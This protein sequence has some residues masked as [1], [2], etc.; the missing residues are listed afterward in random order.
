MAGGYFTTQN[1]RIPGAYV[2][3]STDAQE[4]ITIGNRGIVTMPLSLNW[5]KVR[6]FVVIDNNTDFKAVLGYDILDPQ[7]LII[8]ETLKRAKSIL[9]YRI[10]TG[11]K[12]T[13]IDSSLTV[14][15]KYEGTRGNDITI[16]IVANPDVASSFIVT[17]Y[18][19]GEIVDEQLAS[20][21]GDL[22][23]ND[24]VVFSGTASTAL[25]ASAGIVLTGGTN[26]DATS[27]NYTTYFA[28]CE[29]QDFNVIALSTSDAT[30]KGAAAT[31]VKRMIETEG[32]K[33]Q[34]VMSSYSTAD[35]EGVISVENGVKLE[36]GT[37]IDI[38]TAVGWVAGA[39]A[40]AEINKDLTYEVYEGAVDVTERYTD[41]QIE[42]MLNAGKFFFVPKKLKNGVKKIVV[43]EDINTFVSFTKDKGKEFSINRSIR[44]MFDIGTTI[45]EFWE[46]TYI[47]KVDATD[48]GVNAF[49][50]DVINYF[51]NLQELGAIKNF[52]S[53]ED[54]K[55]TL[56]SDDSA[57]ALVGVQVARAFKKLYM[58]VKLK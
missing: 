47:G 36:D 25:T 23:S 31:F 17:T 42:T 22:Q 20:T 51:S 46:Q 26:T 39:T 48:D 19:D 49:V 53:K 55:V 12:A 37:V 14:T 27:A 5:G 44:T 54:I 43:Q 13:K 24:Y 2:N 57:F 41:T 7:L 15:A 21:I 40:S 18:L 38:L 9:L 11:V 6:E 1:K 35:H 10:N 29:V 56:N 28:S 4:E 33:I 30:I 32:K 34:V 3:F 45:P 58:Q 8:K 16:K 52:N 50:G